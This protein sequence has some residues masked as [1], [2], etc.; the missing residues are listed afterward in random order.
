[1]CQEEE[2]MLERKGFAI[3]CVKLI[4]PVIVIIILYLLF[5]C[6]IG[7]V[8]H[9]NR[10]TE[11][12]DSTKVE[13]VSQAEFKGKYHDLIPSLFK[14]DSIPSDSTKIAVIEVVTRPAD[15]EISESD[16]LGRVEQFYYDTHDKLL[17]T[18]AILLSVFSVLIAFFG[19][20]I[21]YMR[22]T[23]AE[24]Q[25]KIIED[26]LKESRNTTNSLNSLS[27]DYAKLK[28]G[29]ETHIS[30][31][32]IKG[33]RI[34]EK[35][36][37][38]G[39]SYF[40]FTSIDENVR[41]Q[42]RIYVDNT[43]MLE[44]LGE[45]LNDEDYLFRALYYQIIEDEDAFQQE[46]SMCT[47]EDSTFLPYAIVADTYSKMSKYSKCILY[48]D[49][50]IYIDPSQ[51][52]LWHNK[53]VSLWII[54]K[55]K[56]ALACLNEAIRLK[57]DYTKSWFI[58]GIV[59][60]QLEQSEEAIKCYKEAISIKPDYD[61]AWLNQGVELSRIELHEDAIKCIDE[62]I[63]IKPGN[64][65]AWFKKGVILSKLKQPEEAIKCYDEAI[66]F[67][68]DCVEAYNNKGVQLVQLEQYKKAI[69][70]Y[71]EAIRIEP[72]YTEAWFG[73]GVA[74]GKL[75][76]NKEAIK[77]YD[78]VINIKPDDYKSWFNKA[79]ILGALDMYEE[80]I[81]CYEEAIRIQPDHPQ[82][83]YSI[84]GSYAKKR[85]KDKM[86]ESITKAIQLD[87]GFKTITQIDSVF[88]AYWEDPDFKKLV[89]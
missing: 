27:A 45:N 35:L 57:P 82:G 74:L 70:S 4:T 22:S 8:S 34:R 72:S 60:S 46:L 61:E 76:K 39:E 69:N 30:K 55:P 66:R 21:P 53:G 77:C 43:E 12:I 17:G 42:L 10:H 85:D 48:Y 9:E 62:A 58:K 44:A 79:V 1:M 16:I 38:I 52:Q 25:L 68:P 36:G 86:L 50:A 87:A 29:F 56:E 2:I 54:K 40:E 24:E 31:L 51:Y 78:Q 32:R 3:T 49:K 19:G 47:A 5:M 6:T 71:D 23:K 18:L 20:L 37:M 41:N 64:A 26:K 89:E 83:W 13:I 7:R 65:E 33:E 75:G 14:K 73:K 81:M 59:L 88:E 28:E 15:G 11:I 63:K 80:E 67:N 84:S